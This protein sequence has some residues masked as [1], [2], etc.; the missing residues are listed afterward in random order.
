MEIQAIDS[1]KH[2]TVMLSETY[3]SE[4]EMI[5]LCDSAFAFSEQLE[6]N[7][8]VLNTVMNRIQ[9]TAHKNTVESK[10]KVYKVKCPITDKEMDILNTANS[11]INPSSSKL[12]ITK[13]QNSMIPVNKLYYLSINIPLE[14]KKEFESSNS[15]VLNEISK[16]MSFNIIGVKDV[17]PRYKIDTYLTSE[18]YNSLIDNV[19]NTELSQDV[20]NFCEVIPQITKKFCYKKE[21]EEFKAEISNI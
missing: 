8:V 5:T 13:I 19:N 1:G 15:T 7:A 16:S 21:R 6:E 14:F 10:E 9:N 4:R 3:I 18:E 11:K 2:E 12:A 17:E 20:Q